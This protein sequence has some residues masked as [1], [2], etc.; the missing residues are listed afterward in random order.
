MTAPS[1]P[2]RRRIIVALPLGVFALLCLSLLIFRQTP[3][4]V[5]EVALKRPELGT[6]P[7]KTFGAAPTSDIAQT[8]SR[9]RAPVPWASGL[10]GKPEI[11]DVAEENSDTSWQKPEF[12][13]DWAKES[14]S[15]LRAFSRWVTEKA[16]TADEAALSEGTRLA[17][18]RRDRLATLI[19]ENP[20]EA[21]RAAVP[22]ELRETLPAAVA[23]NLETFVEGTGLYRVAVGCFDRNPLAGKADHFF[24][25]FSVG[26]TT[27]RT[28]VYG[29]RLETLSNDQLPGYGIAVGDLLVLEENAVRLLS[30][31]SDQTL[32]QFGSETL[33]LSSAEE[34]SALAERQLDLE[35]TPGVNLSAT[36]APASASPK[37]IAAAS[38]VTTGTKRLLVIRVDFVDHTG[39]PQDSWTDQSI[40][41]NWAAGIV[42]GELSDFVSEF[43]YNKYDVTTSST[44]VTSVYR[45]SRSAFSYYLYD[46]WYA[47]ASEAN[48]AASR[49]GYNLANYQ[50]YIIVFDEIPAV[51]FAGLA[52]LGARDYV[53]I[54]GYFEGGTLAHE[55]FH[56]LGLNHANL[57]VTES[58][59][60]P[61]G[62]GKLE[63]YGDSYDV[64]G[65]GYWRYWIPRSTLHPN[66][67]FLDRLGWLDPGSVHLVKAAGT[68]RIHRY[69]TAS[70]NHSNTLALKIFRK[71]GQYLWVGFR[72]DLFSVYSTAEDMAEGLYVVAQGMTRS[73]GSNLIDF[74]SDPTDTEVDDASL[75][76]GDD[77]F[78]PVGGI[79][80]HPLRFGGSGDQSWVEV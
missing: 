73:R 16:P 77:F 15:V 17:E 11:R 12:A 41:P 78:D 8:G 39:T 51:E 49:H 67:Y 71:S 55:L 59:T 33:G 61:L 13:A 18:A 57:W 66:P 27:Y 23:A 79:Y 37:A 80:L 19:A 52:T 26:D 65:S 43:S 7:A 44:D 46:D 24:R 5:S 34:V 40:T 64:M 53:I 45:M 47:L 3:S 38:A 76:V 58:P 70:A 69:D 6:I 9:N 74:G 22:L 48:T 21:I 60:S 30:S 72:D 28:S 32:V 29:E 20:E 75:N 42:N 25:H 56:N 31:S 14:D 62:K 35:S 10:K 50:H 36:K 1:V 2:P 63:E 68:Y 4:E 54:N